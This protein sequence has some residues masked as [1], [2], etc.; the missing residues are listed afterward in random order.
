MR[1]VELTALF[2]LVPVALW[3]SWVPLGPTLL[4]AL[5]AILVALSLDR[6]FRWGELFSFRLHRPRRRDLLVILVR[7]GIAAAALTT[8][9]ALFLPDLFLAFPRTRPGLF[10]LVCVFYPLVSVLPQ[11]LVYRVF[12]FRR[13][14]PI[15]GSAVP[16]GLFNALA[17]G[18]GHVFFDHWISVA[19][20]AAGGWLFCRTWQRTGSIWLVWLEHA[21]YGVLIF[22]IGLGWFF[23]HGRV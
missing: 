9:T 1:Y 11:E 21:L 3:L 13:Y 5:A 14:G 16:A 22:T 12:F 19:L 17:F 23:Y 10:A 15:L 6:G 2:G 8:A 18:W 4:V 20:S 7:F